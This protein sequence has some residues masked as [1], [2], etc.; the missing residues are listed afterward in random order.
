MVDSYKKSD[1]PVLFF[2]E[3]DKVIAY[4][5]ALDI[6]TCGDTEEQARNRFSEATEVFFKELID[7]GTLDDVLAECGWHKIAS[8]GEWSPPVYRR[9]RQ[10]SV[11]IPIRG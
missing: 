8:T 4:S 3:G 10:E 1:I 5:P 11:K 6:S 9:T 7:M 2:E